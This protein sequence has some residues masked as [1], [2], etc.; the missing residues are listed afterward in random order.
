GDL[1]RMR[2]FLGAGWGDHA[3]YGA[4]DMVM[5]GDEARLVV[6]VLAVR[7][8]PVTLEVDAARATPLRLRLEGHAL[9]ETT[10]GPGTPPV[11]VA[12]PA[13]ALRRGDNT[14]VLSAPGGGLRLRGY[15]LGE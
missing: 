4:G 12:L 13:A 14:L 1:S 7:D 5:A 15:T 10:V 3:H 6:P 9:A 11:L 2:W 8:L